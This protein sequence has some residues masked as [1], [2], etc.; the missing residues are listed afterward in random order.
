MKHLRQASA[1]AMATALLAVAGC[2][3]GGGSYGGGTGVTPTPPA[4]PPPPTGT[5]FTVF[6]R[7]LLVSAKTNE[8]DA[9]VDLESI[10]WVFTDDENETTYDDILAA[11]GP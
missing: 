10:D 1:L 8:T 7:D 2:G 5:N 6:T 4:P 9:P 11:S 3:G